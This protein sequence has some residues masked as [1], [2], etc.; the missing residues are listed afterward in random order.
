PNTASTNDSYARAA[1]SADFSTTAS[2]AST[3]GLS[4]PTTPSEATAGATLIE[5]AVP[6]AQLPDALRLGDEASA[7][8]AESRPLRRTPCTGVA[9]ASASAGSV[10]RTA[11]LTAVRP[12]SPSSAG[13]P[14]ASDASAPLAEKSVSNASPSRL[15]APSDD[16][17]TA[18]DDK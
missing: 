13:S 12:A 17:R 1:A 2:A 5:S 9:L 8:R 4:S 3:N 18:L 15:D 10:C 6:T 7:D 14:T 11:G 16:R